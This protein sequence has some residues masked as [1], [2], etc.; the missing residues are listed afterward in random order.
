[1]FPW[2]VTI[3]VKLGVALI[4]SFNL[5]TRDGECVREWVTCNL[6]KSKRT[7]KFELCSAPLINVQALWDMDV[8]SIEIYRRFEGACCRHLQRWPQRVTTMHD[9]GSNLLRN[10]GNYLT[11]DTVSYT[12]QSLNSRNES[13]VCGFMCLSACVTNDIPDHILIK[14]GQNWK[15]ATESMYRPY[16][17]THFTGQFVFRTIFVPTISNVGA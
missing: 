4:V 9:T 3:V 7:V 10:V 2:P 5:S 16:T 12:R 13:T 14:F 15:V 6:N 11:V 8:L 1:M 17:V